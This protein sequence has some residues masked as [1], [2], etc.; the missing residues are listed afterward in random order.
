MYRAPKISEDTQLLKFRQVP[1]FWREGATQVVWAKAPGHT[2][3]QSRLVK[4]YDN[5]NNVIF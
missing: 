3:K 4:K 5:W 1:Q 2:A